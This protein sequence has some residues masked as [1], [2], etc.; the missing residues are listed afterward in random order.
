MVEKFR[1]NHHAAVVFPFCLSESSIELFVETKD[2]TLIPP[3]Y[4]NGLCPFGGTNVKEDLSPLAVLDREL[5]EEFW[6]KE[7]THET[8]SGILGQ[9]VGELKPAVREYT[10][11]SLEVLEIG[12]MM[13]QSVRNHGYGRDFR[14]TT[15]PPL[16]KTRVYLNS[17]WLTPLSQ[18]EMTY[19][20]DILGRFDGILTRDNVKFRNT[21][22]RSEVVT[23]YD[24]NN[25]N[26]KLIG[27]YDQ[28]LTR[29]LR[30]FGRQIGASEE[31][32]QGV[33]R[34]LRFITC[35][36]LRHA[37]LE[38]FATYEKQGYVYANRQVPS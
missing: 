6:I 23:L 5:D 28:M 10:P 29:M 26:R 8:Y 15:H 38:S 1:L 9:E 34:Y 25:R 17:I 30:I 37:P 12:K 31:E 2:S 16:M 22:H 24:I 13:K 21:G 33:I 4:S 11:P 7:E 20:K 19:I 32:Q 14:V 35:E 3:F 18:E 27:G 36:D